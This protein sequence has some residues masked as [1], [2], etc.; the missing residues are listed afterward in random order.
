MY[1]LK[2][3]DFSQTQ[4]A[5]KLG[6]SVST[7]SRELK[8]NSGQRGYRY[9][10]ADQLAQERRRA[11]SQKA[12]QKLTQRATALIE[13][14]LKQYWSPEQISGRFK[15]QG[16]LQ[17]SKETIYLHIWKD[18]KKGGTLY[19]YLRH[20]GKRYQRRKNILGGRG[21]I[22]NRVGIEQRPS[23]VESK[24]R[25]GDWEA[26]TIIGAQHQGALMSLVDRASKLTILKKLTSK[27]ASEVAQVAIKSLR[28]LK[29]KVHTM[30]FDNGKEFS[31]H[32]QI[33]REL[34]A[35][36]FFA[37][38]YHSWERG[39]NEHTNGLVRQF[40]PK[41]ENIHKIPQEHIKLIEDNLNHRPRKVLNYKTPYEVFF[42]RP[43]KTYTT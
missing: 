34:N 15:Q 29:K 42:A 18:K 1:I 7:I 40:V 4:I 25:I 37:R 31:Q 33:A 30:T 12:A 43:T 20:A 26:D 38:P 10:Q 16:I 5:K 41:K 19:M 32:A 21:Y 14:A 23:V 2:S 22:P 17:I 36:M 9:Q 11:A 27:T 28:A 35:K 13:G 24:A 3:N 39:L 8:R 6:V